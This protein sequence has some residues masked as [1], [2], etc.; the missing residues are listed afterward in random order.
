MTANQ[1]KLRTL[2]DQF[3]DLLEEA[4][5]LIGNETTADPT[6]ITPPVVV[7]PV[8]GL[9]RTRLGTRGGYPI[10]QATGYDNPIE[11]Y[12]VEG[13]PD[14]IAPRGSNIQ[15]DKLPGVVVKGVATANSGYSPPDNFAPAGYEKRMWGATAASG[16]YWIK[17]DQIPTPTTSTATVSGLKTI[18]DYA[19]DK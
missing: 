6:P 4:K 3:I 14:K 13:E 18:A 17:L 19:L 9:P 15:F 1:Q 2:L 7:P 10:V 16:F 12:S 5:A 11:V 8:F